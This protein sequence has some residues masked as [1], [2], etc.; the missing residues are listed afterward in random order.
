MLF[1]RE[2]NLRFSR[3]KQYRS[4]LVFE[5]RN[6]GM[7]MARSSRRLYMV[8]I[9]ASEGSWSARL[10]NSIKQVD[11]NQGGRDGESDGAILL[12]LRSFDSRGISYSAS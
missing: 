2:R 9:D 7:G 11:G 10:S 12:R 5:C 3:S 6:E 8:Q 1:E 4:P